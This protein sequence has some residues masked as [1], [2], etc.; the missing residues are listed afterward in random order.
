MEPTWTQEAISKLKEAKLHLKVATWKEN[1]ECG[2]EDEEE[3][4]EDP[5]M[6]DPHLEYEITLLA[7]PFYRIYN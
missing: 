4:Y 7:P 1:G 2:V 3:P 5:V 6:L